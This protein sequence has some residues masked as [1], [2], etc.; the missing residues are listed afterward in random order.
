M[1][2]SWLTMCKLMCAVSYC[3]T[4]IEDYNT[5]TLS[6]KKYYD[7]DLYERKR[8]LKAAKRGKTLVSAFI[9]PAW[10]V[11]FLLCALS[12]QSALHAR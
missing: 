8:A 11:C 12:G 1:H 3:R 7:L 5:G 4:Y 6:H 9:Y 2:S 10:I